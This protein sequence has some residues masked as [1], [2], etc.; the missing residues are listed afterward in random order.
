MNAQLCILLFSLYSFTFSGAPKCPLGFVWIEGRFT[1]EALHTTYEF[2]SIYQCAEDSTKKFNSTAFMFEK[3]SLT[4]TL[5][6]HA[7]PDSPPDDYSTFCQK[8]GTI[9]TF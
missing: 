5:L 8:L 6:A 2:D 3:F 7:N 9:H 1:G 4:C